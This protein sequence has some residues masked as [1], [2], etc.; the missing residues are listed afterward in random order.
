MSNMIGGNNHELKHEYIRR[1]STL[2]CQSLAR[3]ST[4]R[5]NFHAEETFP[6]MRTVHSSSGTRDA[7]G[8]N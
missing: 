6:D 4:A 8:N 2:R 7:L 5:G 1:D 3:S